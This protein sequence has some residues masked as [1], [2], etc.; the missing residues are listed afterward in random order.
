MAE[1]YKLLQRANASEQYPF[2]WKLFASWDYAI[3]NANTAASK[4]RYLSVSLKVGLPCTHSLTAQRIAH[5]CS[6]SAVM[7]LPVIYVLP[8]CLLLYNYVG[9]CFLL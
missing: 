2:S 8:F 9:R 5:V 3:T 4:K 1:K 6:S 7:A